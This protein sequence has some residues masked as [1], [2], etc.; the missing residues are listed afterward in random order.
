MS[1]YV[2]IDLP[3]SEA[4]YRAEMALYVAAAGELLRLAS[5]LPDGLSRLKRFQA[6][7]RGRLIEWDEVLVGG[8]VDVRAKPSAEMVSFILELRGG[9]EHSKGPGA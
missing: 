3:R 1:E 8:R 9:S 6:E 7:H 5:A 4:T 2:V